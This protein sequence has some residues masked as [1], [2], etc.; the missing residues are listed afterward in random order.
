MNSLEKKKKSLQQNQLTSELPT[1]QL[2]SFQFGSLGV[3][4]NVASS[5]TSNMR[6]RAIYNAQFSLN[7]FS[8]QTYSSQTHLTLTE[9]TSL[10]VTETFF[11]SPESGWSS[12]LR[13]Q[14]LRT[15]TQG[16]VDYMWDVLSLV[17]A[18][19]LSVS[20]DS[21]AMEAAHVPDAGW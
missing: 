13:R 18:P 1:K 5:A 2:M 7:I 11:T 3:A 21:P 16:F 4:V 20:L 19:R 14:I 15:Q 8:F 10:D 6:G 12:L 17:T 9:V